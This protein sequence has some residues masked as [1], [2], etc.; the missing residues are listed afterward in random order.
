[1]PDASGLTCSWARPTE[2]SSQN[3]LCVHDGA[4]QVQAYFIAHVGVCVACS[5]SRRRD[6]A[7]QDTEAKEI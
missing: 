7:N 1:M 5:G 6:A 4:A 2:L 3:M